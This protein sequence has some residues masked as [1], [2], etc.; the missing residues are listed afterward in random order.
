[1]KHVGKV[2]NGHEIRRGAVA[3]NG[4]GEVVLGLGFMLMGENSHHVTVAMKNKLARIERS[5][6]AET[7]DEFRYPKNLCWMKY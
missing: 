2:E 6:L 5:R 7:L 1:M 3:A 4:P